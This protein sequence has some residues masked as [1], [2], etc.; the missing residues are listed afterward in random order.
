M[1]WWFLILAA[2][3]GAALW[4]GMA[5]YLRVRRQMKG[6]VAVIAKKNEVEQEADGL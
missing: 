3:G 4:A 2:S 1:L 5:A 6:P